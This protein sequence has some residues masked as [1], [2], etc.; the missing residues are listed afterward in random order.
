MTKVALIILVI[1]PRPPCFSHKTKAAGK[2]STS[3]IQ[4]CRTKAQPGEEVSLSLF[5]SPFINRG[6][7]FHY[8][9]SLS[10]QSQLW[11]I[12][13]SSVCDRN[14]C[15]CVKGGILVKFNLFLS[16]STINFDHLCVCVTKC[17][18]DFSKKFINLF[19]STLNGITA[20]DDISS[21]HDPK[22]AP[23]VTAEDDKKERM[24]NDEDEN[25][26]TLSF[27]EQRWQ[28]WSSPSSAWKITFIN[29]Y[30]FCCCSCM[31]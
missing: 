14:L 22:V 28:D 19:L 13:W 31:L 16:S 12:I 27:Q 1:W 26:E 24:R 2:A 7:K 29:C 18:E 3:P 5:L 8:L 4:C 25:I 10:L 17:Q 11:L 15:R 23:D 6:R 9:Y 30:C 20:V 21:G